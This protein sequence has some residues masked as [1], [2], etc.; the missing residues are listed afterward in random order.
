[1]TPGRPYA[2]VPTIQ[3]VALALALKDNDS[4][5]LEAAR[6]REYIRDELD[7]RDKKERGD[8][9]RELLERVKRADRP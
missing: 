7:H 4:P 6:A 9:H 8:A 2:E 5:L 1:M 3:L